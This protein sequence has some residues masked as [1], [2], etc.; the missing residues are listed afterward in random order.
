MSAEFYDREPELALLREKYEKLKSGE[1]LAIY[2][3]RR[4]GKTELI[5]EFMKKVE[6]KKFYF[7]VDLS[8]RQ[9]LLDS[10]SNAVQSQ[11]NET[12]HF[13]DFD[14][15]FAFIA[16]KAQGAAGFLLVIDEFQRFLGIAPE[17][18][19]KLQQWWDSELRN[20]KIMAIL[21]G[22]SIG[23]MQKITESRAGALYGR[24]TKLKIS[25]FRYTDFRMMFRG[26]G[27]EEKITR[28][29]VFGGTPYYLEK[30]KGIPSTI[31][32]ISEVVLRKGGAL[33][34]EPK[35]LLEYENV[36]I[37]AKY[38]SILHALASGKEMIKDVQDF[39]K[40]SSNTIP[41]Y[42]RRLDELLDLVGM[43][44]P[45]LGKERL[46]RYMIRDNFFRFWYRFIF[47]N[48]TAL[49]LGN[50]KLVS[51]LLEENLNSYVARVFE[52]VVRE[53]LVLYLNKKIKGVEISFEDIGGWWDRNSNEIDVVAYNN[54]EKKI[55]VGEVKWT[56]KPMDVEV[57]YE[58]L[59]KAKMINFSG[60]YQYLLVSKSG[61]TEQC[62]TKIKELGILHLDIGEIEKLFDSL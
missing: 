15:F 50:I 20:Q 12:V 47:P 58:L 48:Q 24:A 46:G 44:N 34:E 27:E 18:I 11:L 2:G 17:F 3:R 19:T 39:T 49:N 6:T 41:A 7:Y 13:G 62:K 33:A 35:N 26:L 54:K 5:K 45:V 57:L 37:H 25:P 38:N 42:I 60:T 8:G 14:S 30:I 1:L 43:K 16:K 52:S 22:S 51:S 21:V 59:K 31:Q 53:L 4:V 23:M 32:A 36:R 28:Y 56:N 40:I 61:F 10:L 9:E 55:L 29:A